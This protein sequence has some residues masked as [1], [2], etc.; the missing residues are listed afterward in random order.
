MKEGIVHQP[1]LFSSHVKASTARAMTLTRVETG[2]AAR[3]RHRMTGA[4][5]IRVQA[6]H[7]VEHLE[8]LH[9]N[10]AGVRIDTPKF[11]GQVA[12]RIRDYHGPSD[13]A[14]SSPP[15]DSWSSPTD[16]MS[17]QIE[18]EWLDG[19]GADDVLWG[20]AWQKPIRDYLP[21][22]TA[23]ALKFVGVVDPALTHDLY[24]DKPWALSPF[25]STMN[26][27]SV[28]RLQDAQR[29]TLDLPA[30]VSENLDDLL[31][32]SV[33][34]DVRTDPWKRRQYFARQ[35]NRRQDGLTF[36]KNLHFKA[37]FCNGYIDFNTLSLKL[38]IHLTFPLARYWDGQPVTF[39]CRRRNTNKDY[40]VVTFTLDNVKPVNPNADDAQDDG[41]AE[42]DAQVKKAAEEAGHSV[43][44]VDELGV[45]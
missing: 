12:V 26:Y 3:N 15:A 36:D 21:W 28:N 29:A 39:V 41:K 38:P 4:P 42:V 1:K 23:A 13:D 25:I 22:G 7:D 8:L 33:P 40:F 19:A 10:G 18:G 30:K 43:Q 27:I 44:Q 6:G 32:Q 20:N 24:A 5:R 31:P 16:T 11:R 14:A 45:D 34:A 37:D 35:E 9:V 17:I 2:V